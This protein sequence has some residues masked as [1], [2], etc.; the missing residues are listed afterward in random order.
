MCGFYSGSLEK[1]PWGTLKSPVAPDQ[2]LLRAVVICPVA[3]LQPRTVKT[4]IASKGHH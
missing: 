3:D 4:N 1:A 2:Q